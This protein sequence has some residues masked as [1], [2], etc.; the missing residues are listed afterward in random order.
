MS[1]AMK[2]QK[3]ETAPVGDMVILDVGLP[4]AVVGAW[5]ELRFSLRR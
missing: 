4:Y 5:N 3:M 2:W 1:E